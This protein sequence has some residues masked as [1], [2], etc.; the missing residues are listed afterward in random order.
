MIESTNS[1][2]FLLPHLEQISF[3]VA[4]LACFLVALPYGERWGPSQFLVE[5]SGTLVV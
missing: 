1:N 4:G 5:N 3:L 2:Q